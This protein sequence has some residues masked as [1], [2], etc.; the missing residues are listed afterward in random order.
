[1]QDVRLAMEGAFE[2][3]VSA[4]SEPAA[5]PLLHLWQRPLPAALAALGL[6][7][8][9]GLAVWTGTRPTDTGRPAYL[10][11][12][13]PT[14]TSET[15]FWV[16]FIDI[17][18]DGQH[19]VVDTGTGPFIL[20]DLDQPGGSVAIAGTEGATHPL[21]SPD[22]SSIA[23]VANNVLQRRLLSGG[24]PSLITTP[25]AS[26]FFGASW[27]PD[28]RIL[29]V[30]GWPTNVRAV[31]AAPG[32][33]PESVIEIDPSINEVGHAEPQLLPD[34][35][36]LYS[37]WDGT[38][39]IAVADPETGD[40]EVL[41]HNGHT[42]RY[43]STGHLVYAQDHYLFA[44]TFDLDTLEVGAPVQ[45]LDHLNFDAGT[46]RGNFAISDNGVLAYLTGPDELDR[47]MVKIW[48]DGGREPL[49]DTRRRYVGLRI[50]PDGRQL[51]MNIFDAVGGYEVWVYDMGRDD[52]HAIAQD[53]GWD[54]RAVWSADGRSI[55]WTTETIGT[56]DL[57]I[58]PADASAPSRP[59]FVDERSK[60]A[61]AA[62]PSGKYLVNV[63]GNEQTMTD[64][65]VAT[66]TTP[67]D[68]DNPEHFL[69]VPGLQEAGSFSPDGRH[70]AYDSQEF[71]VTE[72]YARPYP[73]REEG[74]DWFRKI[75]RDGGREPVWVAND[76]IVYRQGTRAMEVTVTDNDSE[77]AFSDPIQLF[78]GLDAAWDISP[79]G[80]YFVSLELIE[81]P[82][83][84][85]VLDWFEELQRLVPTP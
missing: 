47:T 16:N 74:R 4:P 11:L 66:L 19:I 29:F 84:M 18:G 24:N 81:P 71:G 59:L 12:A 35:R 36:I 49:T 72:V 40:R 48:T 27:A 22:G 21:L 82:R 6:V 44:R 75:S 85:V 79:D 80:T 1:M 2:T 83:L 69:P 23:Y 51:V 52:F 45:I 26:D 3:T 63:T 78:D 56:A 5:P 17:S 31:P 73:R 70:V 46:G 53:E 14:A 76:R 13:L 65:W 32:G 50:S 61:F 28:D 20:Y 33:E 60:Y 58:R 68:P 37:G 77:L 7:L 67:D 30:P 62:H 10:E 54:L 39:F 57:L 25:T 64:L 8:I 43:V 38:W 15:G 9:T 55:V 42:G 41:F 34:G